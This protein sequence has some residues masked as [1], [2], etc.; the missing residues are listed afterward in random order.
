M[1]Q[2]CQVAQLDA[3]TS[4]AVPSYSTL[5]SGPVCSSEMLHAKL[6]WLPSPLFSFAMFLFIRI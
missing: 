5:P 2:K 1:G 6:C 4:R 3:K